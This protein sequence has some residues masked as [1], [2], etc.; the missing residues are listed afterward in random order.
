[1][2]EEIIVYSVQDGNFLVAFFFDK[3]LAEN[4][5]KRAYEDYK[6][7]DLS[8]IEKKVKMEVINNNLKELDHE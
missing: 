7:N 4:Y 2:N 5:I 8:I 3:F 1:M 6:Y